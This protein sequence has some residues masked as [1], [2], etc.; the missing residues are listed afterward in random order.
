MGRKNPFCSAVTRVLLALWQPFVTL[1][2][3]VERL[4][5]DITDRVVNNTKIPHQQKEHQY[6]PT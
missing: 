4:I 2:K 6:A 1:F 3:V 5:I